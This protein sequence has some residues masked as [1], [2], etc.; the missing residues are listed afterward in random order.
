MN[1][2]NKRS[3]CCI[4]LTCIDFWWCMCDWFRF[5]SSLWCSLV[6]NFVL[7]AAVECAAKMHSFCCCFEHYNPPQLISCFAC[8]N[9]RESK[10]S[11]WKNSNFIYN[12]T[13]KYSLYYFTILLKFTDVCMYGCAV[14]DLCTSS[15]VV[16]LTWL[17]TSWV[18]NRLLTYVRFSKLAQFQIHPPLNI[19]TVNHL[20]NC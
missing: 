15:L 12:W 5:Y 20:A 4:V 16:T 13:L 11:K 18:E 17:L 14:E 10:C 8:P 6:C 2:T 9:L 3:A 7:T 1:N 19:R